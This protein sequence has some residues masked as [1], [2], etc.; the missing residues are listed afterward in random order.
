MNE[1]RLEYFS[2]KLKG[3]SSPEIR[4]F[5]SAMVR[6]LIEQRD[7]VQ[8]GTV[9]LGKQLREFADNNF[10][11]WRNISQV[12]GGGRMSDEEINDIIIEGVK[13]NDYFLV[14]VNYIKKG[15]VPMNNNYTA[16]VEESYIFYD[17][18]R[19]EFITALRPEDLKP[20]GGSIGGDVIA[21]EQLGSLVSREL[22]NIACLSSQRFL[23]NII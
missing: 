6:N 5:N 12:L 23:E 14:F 15:L 18:T 20:E 21:T 2:S 10:S 4:G 22:I 7:F 9:K 11:T 16:T 13:A 17:L 3:F 19:Q 1:E 8:A